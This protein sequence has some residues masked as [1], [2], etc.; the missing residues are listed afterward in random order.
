MKYL[1]ISRSN[2][3]YKCLKNTFHIEINAYNSSLPQVLV[4]QCDGNLESPGREWEQSTLLHPNNSTAI[5]SI[6]YLRLLFWWL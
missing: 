1:T 4:L 5:S 3:V 2:V 6:Q